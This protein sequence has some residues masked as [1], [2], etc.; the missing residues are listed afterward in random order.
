MRGLLWP[1][2]FFLLP[3]ACRIA[4]GAR[5]FAA[6]APPAFALVGHKICCRAMGQAA[7]AWWCLSDPSFCA[8]NF[9]LASFSVPAPASLV[10]HVFFIIS[11]GLR[12]RAVLV[13]EPPATRHVFASSS[14]S[15]R[16]DLLIACFLFRSAPALV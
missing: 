4:F 16:L 7:E 9:A 10:P 12:I 2:G 14:L 11:E 1:H 5:N 13:G 8:G 3:S 6:T 15:L